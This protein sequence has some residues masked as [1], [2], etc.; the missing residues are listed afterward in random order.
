[1]LAHGAA[2]PVLA[3]GSRRDTLSV[4][5]ARRPAL[6]LTQCACAVHV[7]LWNGWDSSLEG[8]AGGDTVIS[9]GGAVAK[10]LQRRATV[11][12][13]ASVQFDVHDY[14]DGDLLRAPR[15]S[16]GR[17]VGDPRLPEQ[18]YLPA[19]GRRTRSPSCS[20]SSCA[21]SASLSELRAPVSRGD[22]FWCDPLPT[23]AT[24]TSPLSWSRGANLEAKSSL[25]L[26]LVSEAAT[27]QKA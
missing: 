7:Q 21:C 13:L 22:S 10:W 18:V 16:G 1:M 24:P 26:S 19:A 15:P 23:G 11:A 25:R 8:D 9:G 4:V 17:P 6:V 27:Q 14:A 2:L 3:D 12:I 5:V 20:Q